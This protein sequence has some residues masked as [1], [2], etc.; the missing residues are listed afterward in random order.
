MVEPSTIATAI[1]ALAALFGSGG[2]GGGDLRQ[3]AFKQYM[4]IVVNNIMHPQFQHLARQNDHTQEQLTNTLNHL[5]GAIDN[6]LNGGNAVA[7][8]KLREIIEAIEQGNRDNVV[9]TDTL[10]Q[11]LLQQI[12]NVISSGNNAVNSSEQRVIGVI[13]ETVGRVLDSVFEAENTITDD[14]RGVSFSIDGIIDI[15]KSG[16]N[17]EIRNIIN[18]PSDLFDTLTRDIRGAIES[19]SD[20]YLGVISATVIDSND[21]MRLSLDEGNEIAAEQASDVKKIVAGGEDM[22]TWARQQAGYAEKYGAPMD[23]PN[24]FEQF[25]QWLGKM[26]F[27][28]GKEAT[29][30]L[31][32]LLGDG[33]LPDKAESDCRGPD[34][35]LPIIGTIG[36]GLIN[37]L[38][39]MLAIGAV[40]I[41]MS[42]VRANRNLQ[43]Y[44]LCYPD[45]LMP[46]GDIIT[47]V[48]RGSMSTTAAKLELRKQGYTAK[49]SDAL[50]G[51]A[52]EYPPLDILYALHLRGEITNKQFDAGLQ[53]HGFYGDWADGL[54]KLEF[55]I[56]PPQDLITMA[57]REVFDE[58]TARAQGQFDGFPKDFG[59]FAAMQGISDEWAQRYWAAHWR[60]PS[61]Q[62]GFEMLHRG[63]IDDRKLESLLVALD[64]MPGWRD[65]IKAISFNPLT[66]VDVRRMHA[67]GVLNREEVLKAYKDLGYDNHNAELMVRFTEEYNDGE[68]VIDIDV[69]SDLTR[70]TILGF[71]KDR[72]IDRAVALGLLLSAGINAIAAELFLQDTDLDSERKERQDQIDIVMTKFDVGRT[73]LDQAADELRGLGL[74][75]GEEELQLLALEKKAIAKNTL[76]SKTDLLRFVAAGLISEDDFI[77]VME[78]HGYDPIWSA[79]YLQITSDEEADNEA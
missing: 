43:N 25:T 68:S 50:I 77:T 17:A 56:P 34:G 20:D 75:R 69:A 45:Q 78:K 22:A 71:Y 60:L 57:V 79:M 47:S 14:I 72:I 59:K 73:T 8:E 4:D 66:R 67:L 76:P 49:T 48:R 40:P 35:G 53:A 39:S 54:K 62:M 36:G 28:N 37:W 21:L 6:G 10:T 23:L 5:L 16:I 11:V 55:F 44:R 19:V 3:D 65:A 42:S 13:G 61:E 18:I 63:V 51:F 2:N 52:F 41:S 31:R 29:E 64:I 30:N 46:E 58:P 33:F 27:E 9:A 24:V 70:S 7:S 15:L 12:G 38:V 74:T 26:M 1:N 32:E